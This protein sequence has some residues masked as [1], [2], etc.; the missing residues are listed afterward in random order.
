[1]LF[2]YMEDWECG[3]EKE[4]IFHLVNSSTPIRF[5]ALTDALMSS[6]PTIKTTSETPQALNVP[7]RC[8]YKPITPT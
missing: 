1:M 8:N 5:S 2:G 7:F 3:E 6:H 4:N